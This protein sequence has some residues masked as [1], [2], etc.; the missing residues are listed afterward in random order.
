MTMKKVNTKEALEYIS[1][2]MDDGLTVWMQGYAGTGKSTMV[3]DLAKKK[4][5]ELV[6][7]RLSTV[8]IGDLVMRM[9]NK[10]R[11]A[12][13]E[14]VNQDFIKDKAT[15]YLFDEFLHAPRSLQK[16]AYQVFLDRKL[17]NYKLPEGSC[18]IALSNPADEVDSDG[19][20]RPM[21]D[22]MDFKLYLEFDLKEWEKWSF[23]N[24][25]RS[26]VISFVDMFADKVINTN[27]DD[28]P[29]TPRTWEKV[30]KR[31]IKGGDK[32]L[33]VLPHE[34]GLLFKSFLAKINKFKNLDDYLDGKTKLDDDLESQFA[35]VSAISN[36]I[37][38]DK[39]DPIVV[40][41]FDGKVKGIREEVKVFGN[42]S[43]LQMHKQVMAGGEMKKY[44]TNVDKS[45]QSKLMSTWKDLGYL[46]DNQV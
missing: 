38:K 12:M 29:L 5:M 44:W 10:E 40:K 26:E 16:M 25:M 8:D 23:D 17:G 2:A 41:W 22:R 31:L 45:I 1:E 27:V 7:T 37:S 18:V 14:L 13:V 21:M 6:D 20:D 24:G 19:I 39:K 35:F 32:Y 3:K 43:V 42:I 9:P 15:V 46:V 33:G 4:G 34:T 28:I 30:S 11:T 36:K